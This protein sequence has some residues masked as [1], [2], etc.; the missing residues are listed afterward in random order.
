[1]RVVKG[2]VGQGCA[3]WW[4]VHE[5]SWRSGV[6]VECGAL[7]GLGHCPESRMGDHNLV[8]STSTP[9]LPHNGKAT[10][11]S[12]GLSI[13]WGCWCRGGAVWYRNIRGSPGYPGASLGN[14][15]GSPGIPGG[16]PGIPGAGGGHPGGSPGHPGA[17]TGHRGGSP[18]QL[19]NLDLIGSSV[20][21]PRVL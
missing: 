5:A 13:V 2:H 3:G 18:G 19:C 10:E 15:G 20:A 21:M 7:S 17:N 11:G 8:P 9:P 4:W 16:S 14:P 6:C 12:Q 1:M